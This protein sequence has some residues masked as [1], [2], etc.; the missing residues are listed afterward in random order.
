MHERDDSAEC[1][2]SQF[3]KRLRDIEPSQVDDTVTAVFEDGTRARGNLLIGADG[4]N[5]KVRN[6]LLG[7]DKG[8]LHALPLMGS[9][10]VGALS[11]EISKKLRD[12]INGEMILGYHPL[13][14]VAFISRTQATFSFLA[15]WH[16]RTM[17]MQLIRVQ[18]MTYPMKAA[19]RRGNGCLAIHGDMTVR[20]TSLTPWRS[21]GYGTNGVLNCVSHCATRSLQRRSIRHFGAIAWVSG[22][23][24][25]GTTN[26]EG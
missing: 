25:R 14:L 5:S 12:D 16:C 1:D 11:A 21:V 8:A 9:M 7:P 23:P 4:A 17:F 13:G 26:R 20:T 18:S 2:G 6:Y 24:L 10:A 19:Q 3:G 15:V 22:L